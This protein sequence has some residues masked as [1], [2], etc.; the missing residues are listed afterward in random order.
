MLEIKASSAMLGYLNAESPYTKDGWFKTGDL[1]EVKG[2]YI[3]ILGRKSEIINVGGEKVYPQEV[4]NIIMEVENIAEAT[5]YSEK[6]IILGN[7]VCAK[8]S[9]L[10][11]KRDLELEKKKIK[12]HCLSMLERYKV[13]IK[14]NISQEKQFGGRFKRKDQ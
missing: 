13:P 2:E 14:I 8:V 3:K 1:V 5:V 12:A 9:L 7:Y 6:N 4:E 11:M 10:D